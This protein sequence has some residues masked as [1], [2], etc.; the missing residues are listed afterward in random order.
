MVN[1]SR[2]T[3]RGLVGVAAVAASQPWRFRTRR[4][5]RRATAATPTLPQP[6]EAPNQAVSTP[7]AGT[8]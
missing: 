4:P 1:L 2:N 5:P 8:P 6:A 3:L 7:P